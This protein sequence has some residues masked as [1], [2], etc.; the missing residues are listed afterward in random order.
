MLSRLNWRNQFFPSR[1]GG[2][3]FF[4]L[5]VLLGSSFSGL[6]AESRSHEIHSESGAKGSVEFPDFEL[7]DRSGRVWRLS[8]FRGNTVFL[9]FWATWCPPCIEEIPSMDLLNSRMRTRPFTMIAISVD[10]SWGEIE[11]FL[12]R[13]NRSPSFLILHDPQKVYASGILGIEKYPE[14]FVISKEGRLL[15]HYQGAVDWLSPK[16]V[17]EMRSF[18][19]E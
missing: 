2:I 1:L 18:L 8:D 19:K 12:R 15:K 7:R 16:A 5:L 4:C 13:L 3:V 6:V 11:G 10:E 9:N 14:T 17:E